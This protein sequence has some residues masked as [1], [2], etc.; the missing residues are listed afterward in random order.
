[1]KKLTAL[2]LAVLMLAATMTSCGKK[3]ASL[4]LSQ[5]KTMA[6][7]FAYDSIGDGYTEE[8]YVYAFEK[9]GIHYRVRT[10]MP[11]DVSDALWAIDFFDEEKES[12]IQA[13][14]GPLP[15]EKAENLDELMLS[16][17]E[18]KALVGKTGGYLLEN[19]WYY[20]GHNLDTMEFWM[21]KDP[22]SYTVIFDGKLQDSDDF[23]AEEAIKDLKI[24]SVTCSG[25]GNA[26]NI[27]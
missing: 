20:S 6:D 16:D 9:D 17:E 18:L 10:T 1:M 3:A 8:I 19:G 7:A 13:L 5:F 26:A 14:I 24:T 2:F 22:F 25:I 11:Q 15:V 23:D 27:D 4:D 21:S 12:K